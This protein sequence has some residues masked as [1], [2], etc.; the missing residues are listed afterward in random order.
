MSEWQPIEMAPKD[1]NSLLLHNPAWLVRRVREGFWRSQGHW[2]FYGS[3]TLA[4]ERA[5]QPTHYMRM[6][7]PPI[8]QSMGEGL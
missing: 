4:G 5:Y 2:G 6:P 8:D 1:G 7:A 3:L